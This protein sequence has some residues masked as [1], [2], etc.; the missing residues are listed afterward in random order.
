MKLANGIHSTNAVEMITAAIV[1]LL[2]L[3]AWLTAV[4]YFSFTMEF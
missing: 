2:C 1:G 4:L 3:A